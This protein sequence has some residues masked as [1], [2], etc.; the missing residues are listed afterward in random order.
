MD[1]SSISVSDPF[2]DSVVVVEDGAFV[3]D[4]DVLVDCTVVGCAV[5]GCAVVVCAVVVC[6]VV[7][8]VVVVIV[9]GSPSKG[10]T[11]VDGGRAHSG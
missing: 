6:A 8:C 11:G 4:C 2:S 5:V 9:T 10:L 1:D 7:D 3:V